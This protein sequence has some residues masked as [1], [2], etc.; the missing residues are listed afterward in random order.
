MSLLF[1]ASEEEAFLLI[2]D[3]FASKNMKILATNHPSHIR[4][5]FGSWTSISLNNAKGEVEVEITKRNGGSYTNLN[6]SFSKEYLLAL[7]IAILGTLALCVVM[8]WRATRDMPQINPA[9]TGN[10]LF[11]VS[12]ITVGLSAVMFAAAIGLVVYS[13]ALTR[14]R[15]VEEFNMFTQS[16]SSQKG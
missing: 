2:T 7:I 6:F 3:Y 9:D 12:L 16:L 5:E 10:F 1:N 13:T 14:R 4:A 11:K 8:W 15:F